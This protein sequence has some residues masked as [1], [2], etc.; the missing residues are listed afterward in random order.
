MNTELITETPIESLMR[1]IS[2]LSFIL[3]FPTMI[4]FN[5]TNNPMYVLFTLE[6]L[7]LGVLTM[8]AHNQYAIM[9]IRNEINDERWSEFEE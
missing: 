8:I 2:M 6:L 1:K 7:A 5:K 9:N 3:M 4:Y